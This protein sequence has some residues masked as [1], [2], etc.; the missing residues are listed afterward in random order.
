MSFLKRLFQRGSGPPAEQADSE[1]ASDTVCPHVALIPRWDSADDMGKPDKVSRYVCEAC[2]AGF[3]REEGDQ[4]RASEAER[5]RLI[6]S[7]RL[8]RKEGG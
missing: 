3:S 5:V 2:K 6:E 8:D 1:P 4:L 7:E